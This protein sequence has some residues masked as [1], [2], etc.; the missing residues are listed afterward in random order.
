MISREEP[1]EEI[2]KYAIENQGMKTLAQ[3]GRELVLQGKTTVEELVKVA[4][5]A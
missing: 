2:E 5:Y 1:V 4:Y 3:Q